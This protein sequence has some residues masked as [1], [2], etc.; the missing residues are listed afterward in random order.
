MNISRKREGRGR[1][2]RKFEEMTSDISDLGVKPGSSRSKCVRRKD[3]GEVSKGMDGGVTE[4]VIRMLKGKGIMFKES[5]GT[6]EG[7][8]DF[9]KSPISCIGTI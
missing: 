6:R 9:T 2:R 4:K 3:A 8:G 5:E 7:G 1:G